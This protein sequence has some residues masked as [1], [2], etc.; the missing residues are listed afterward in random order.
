MN[1]ACTNLRELQSKY[2]SL[3]LRKYGSSIWLLN[4]V[5][6]KNL[7]IVNQVPVTKD[8]VELL[9]RRHQVQLKCY[10]VQKSKYTSETESKV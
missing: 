4:K 1:L 7:V 9:Q 2:M 8:K 6:V 3:L 5:K 10:E